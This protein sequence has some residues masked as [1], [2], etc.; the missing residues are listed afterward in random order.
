MQR[1]RE[2]K[3]GGV[4]LRESREI[5]KVLPRSLHSWVE[6]SRGRT[7][8]GLKNVENQAACL[9]ES[10]S[11]GCVGQMKQARGRCWGHRFVCPW[12]SQS[13]WISH[14]GRRL[15]GRWQA[16]VPGSL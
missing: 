16:A 15:P 12:P 13:V 9:A 8:Q 14:F 5:S 10:V 1:T 4:R 7:R 2:Q 6:R 11:V 3:T